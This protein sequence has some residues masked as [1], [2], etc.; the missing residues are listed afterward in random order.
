MKKPD[1]IYDNRALAA[2]VTAWGLGVS[3]L[4][5]RSNVSRSNL[6]SMVNGRLPVREA[7]AKLLAPHLGPDVAWW[8]LTT[9][10][11]DRDRE[12]LEIMQKLSALG[13]RD[14]RWLHQTIHE[15]AE[16]AAQSADTPPAGPKR[17]R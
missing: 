12:I 17:R 9:V 6:S 5:R 7:M 4:A 13:E 8:Q 1:P 15:L 14:R 11:D 10:R 16:R 2:A 3:E